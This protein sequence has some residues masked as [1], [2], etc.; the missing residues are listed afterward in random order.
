MKIS[1]SIN[2][3]IFGL[4]ALS[5]TQTASALIADDPEPKVVFEED[6]SLVPAIPNYY[7]GIFLNDDTNNLHPEFFHAPGWKGM[8]IGY[9]RYAGE[10]YFSFSDDVYLQTPPL[11]LSADGGKV[12]ITFEYRRE[13]W[14]NQLTTTDNV[15]VELRNRANGMDTGITG[16]YNNP[17]EVNTEWKEYSITLTGGT[18]DCSVRFW[19]GSYMGLFRN[20]KVKQVRPDIDVPVADE[21]TDY[22]GD[23][24]TAHWREVAGA[25]N[26]LLSIFSLDNEARNYV[27]QDREVSGTEYKATGLNPETLYYYTVKAYDGTLTSGESNIIRC[28]GIPKPTIS[29][30]SNITKEGFDVYWDEAQNADL[31][32]LETTLVHTASSAER[33]YLLDE[34]FLNTPGQDASPDSPVSS[35]DS[36]LWLD[37]YMNRS[38][39]YVKQPMFARDCITLNNILAS[40][41]YYGEIDGPTMDL[42]ANG[43][44]VTVEM[45]VRALESGGAASLGL[46][47]LNVVPKV[48]QFTSDKIVDK[49]ELWDADSANEG[50]STSWADRTFTLKG[51]NEESYIAIQAYGY[52]AL[53]QIDRLAIYQELEAGDKVRVPY[54]SYIIDDCEANISTNGEK[55][56]M[57]NDAFE[58]ILRGANTSDKPGEVVYSDWSDPRTVRIPTSGA[59]MV[60]LGISEM[61]VTVDGNRITV[62]NPTHKEITIFSITGNTIMRSTSEIIRTAPLQSGVYII[63]GCG[64]AVKVIVR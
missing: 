56:N 5:G 52:G 34:D 45:R 55:F 3:L 13:S 1:T 11:E 29:R 48:N 14:D 36:Y 39:W 8:N 25:Q 21:F 53:V 2:L 16:I 19:G 60:P 51:G 26:Y 7:G 4:L 58:C 28:F 38:N 43:G 40:M 22:T 47:M 62:N 44:K 15:Y 54:R 32:Q 31:Y 64:K 57:E 9:G 24:F 33:Y 41:G 17:V 12:T 20:L 50:L 6:F 49:I 37:D 63:S 42:S 59:G 27:M 35:G 61:N 23:S 18:A 10:V 30:F 46:Y